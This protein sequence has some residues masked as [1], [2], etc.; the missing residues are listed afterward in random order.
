MAKRAPRVL[1]LLVGA[2][3]CLAGPADAQLLRREAREPLVVDRTSAVPGPILVVDGP[4]PGQTVFGVVAVSGWVLS[5]SSID[6][7][8]LFLDESDI[9]V[10]RAV[11]NQP[12][13]DIT[14]AFPGYA[15]NPSAAAGWITSFLARNLTDGAHEVTLAVTES[16]VP[17]PTLFGPIEVIVDNAINQAPFGHLD[18]PVGG[19]TVGAN[20]SFPVIG[21]AL[22]DS[23]INHIDFLVDGQVWATAIG[24]G[25]AGDAIYGGTRP[26]V[27]AAFPDFPGPQPKSLYSGFLANL[28]TT[29][30]LN[31]L[32]VVS[33]R[34]TDDQGSA[35][36]LGSAVVQVMNN[37]SL[38]GPFGVLE[39][40][41]DE[42]TLICGPA[43][44]VIPPGGPCPSPCFP[45]GGGGAV[46]VSFF[47]NVVKGWALDVG[48][49]LDLG[50]VSWVELMLDGVILSN[51]RTDCTVSGSAFANCYGLSRPDIAHLYQGYVNSANSG[52]QFNFGLSRDPTVGL[53]DI[54][55]PTPQGVALAGFT[56]PGKHTLS[57]RVG[58]EEETVTEFGAMSVNITCDSTSS[59][60]DRAS[61]GDVDSP[62]PGQGTAGLF[63]VVGWAFDLDGVVSSVD[64]VV[65]GFLIANLN[66]PSGT[67]GLR[68][69]DVVAKDIRVTSP[70]VGFAYALNTTVLGDSEHDLTVY[71]NAGGRRTLIGRRKFVVFNN[72]PIK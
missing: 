65:D 40:P 71:V 62:G 41:L 43:V 58:D 52:F 12:R 69:D 53:F 61:F 4:R 15:A 38:L 46:P 24:R 2:S 36:D 50:Q 11:L 14:A 18:V 25:G 32:H 17:T 57:L 48:A 5:E 28:D 1:A 51:T 68:R 59:N 54:F 63:P 9:P 64:L 27:Y 23:D 21:W 3:W 42:A 55:I 26:D 45:T 34:A 20:G 8:E 31:G 6:K 7:I 44:T 70:F 60:P 29:R 49:R 35:A 67:Y 47:P 56:L 19:A 10:N 39:H 66:V 33:V 30:L 22:D 37:G 16:G 72:T 13:P